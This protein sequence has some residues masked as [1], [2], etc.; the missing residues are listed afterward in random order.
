MTSQL[1]NP[2]ST[3]GGGVNFES[4]V[5]ATFV[6]LM[7][8]GGHAPCLPYWPIVEIKLQ[9]KID[10]FDTD[11]LV[12]IVENV[13][14]KER[15][16][17]LG[18]VKHS[19]GITTGNT[20]FGEV[21]QAAWND[22]NNANIFEKDKDVIALITGPLS[23]VD[24]E[25]VWVL[26]HARTN[27]NDAQRFFRNIQTANFSSKI[28]REKLQVI[29]D[30][31]K[32]ANDGND[33][34]DK[35]FHK[36]LMSFYLLGYDLG[37]EEGVV[38]SLI[39]SHISQFQSDDSR[40]AW[41]R[42][43]EFTCNR[44]QHAGCI[45][46]S[47]L[48]SELT[49][50]FVV[51]PVNEFP[52]ALTLPLV[53][54]TVWTQH[55]DATYLAL[56]VLVGSW[57]DKSQCDL[58]T[59]TQLFGISY[60]EWLRK[61]REILHISDSPLSLKNGVWGVANRVELWKQLSSRILDRDLEAFK[62]LAISVL[63]EPDP[64][65]E[66]A[67]EERYAARVRG[68][69]LSYSA[70]LRIGVAEGL[71][72]LGS[73]LVEDANWSL[74]KNETICALVV[75]AV[76]TDADWVLWGSLNDCLPSL[77]EAA[78]NEFL[79]ATEV[80]L[81]ATPCPF[82]ELFAQ[83]G[84]GVTGGNY[85]VGLLWAL[86]ALAW[87]EQ[88]LVRVCVVLANLS[89]IDPGGRSG[90]RPSSSLATILLPWLPQ[91]LASVEKRKVAIKTILNEQP[92][93]GWKVL[94]RLLPNQYKTSM[95]TYKP[96][97]R[98]II[99]DDWDNEVTR[100][101]YIEQV[102]FYSELA[103]KTAGHDV[104]RLSVLIDQFNNL[105]KTAFD[106]LLDVFASQPIS[107]FPEV[108]KLPL[109]TRLTKFTNKH[110]K[111]SNAKW[112]L[113]NELVVR[114][115]QA[116]TQLAP[117]S[118]FNLYQH[119][120]AGGDFAFYEANSDWDEQQKKLNIRRETAILEI[121]RE[122]G[123][124]GVIRFAESVVLPIQVGI[125]LG[126]IGCDVF[127]P[128]LLPHFLD[129]A[130]KKRA[131]L[132]SGFIRSK[133]HREGWE[134]CDNLEKSNWIPEQV[135]AFLACLPFIKETWERASD[136]LQSH[137]SEYWTRIDI[138]VYSIDSELAA[139]IDKLIEHGRPGVAISCLGR[140]LYA[141]QPVD[142]KQCVQALLAA[143]SNKESN[144]NLSQ[145]EILELIKF[146]QEE[147]SV[148]KDEL[149][150]VEWAYLPLLD[151]YSGGTPKHLEDKL[152]SNPSFFCEVVQ[153]IY[154][155]QKKRHTQNE[156]TKESKAI[157]TNAWELL[158]HWKKIPG[159]LSDGSFDSEQFAEW[160]KQVKNICTESGHLEVALMSVGE[161][162]VYAP[163]DPSGL[164]MHHTVAKELNAQDAEA[165]RDGFRSGKYKSIG[166]Q[167]VD[168]SG[169]PERDLAIQFR[170]QAEEIENA[171]FYRFAIT[172]RE[173]A[174]TYDYQANKVVD[175]YN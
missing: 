103:I 116:T 78:P 77:A 121:F 60:D 38:L 57:Q 49:S 164:W 106:Q 148:D 149:Y 4:H 124:E 52:L 1:S 45:T 41:S 34:S 7:L 66:L 95:G 67:P 156:T 165:M 22:F 26:N 53:G 174:E 168:P 51:K 117:T 97:W 129:S 170:K 6:T 131:A 146:L 157:A 81:Q 65:F 74:G 105:P 36:F 108:K 122:D 99:P 25:V 71:A 119:L 40:L 155:S 109:W 80:A 138:N 114:I 134:W 175:Q 142:S 145:Y 70:E 154:R 115:E 147:P 135:G 37:E 33:L 89:A 72:I 100:Q 144:H 139:G 21:I 150:R 54:S 101:E 167:F 125:A 136:W 9:G 48:P 11:D 31:L 43:L 160:I 10:G 30:H 91:T 85:L 76:L 83:E 98:K 166:V 118:P 35:V 137:E 96:S 20:I 159:T 132:V 64:A 75:R 69:V 113:S 152:A 59:I 123:I 130:N 32:A 19:I 126:A 68:K 163:S 17:L 112:A 27:K 14:S 8:T 86:E 5:Q 128:V 94:V 92:E 13:I 88:Y 44:N 63:Q 140:M 104:P 56:S 102:C 12:V 141:K 120:F 90:N 29:R 58:E 3:G 143:V 73:Q 24:A 127:D 171:G 2:F 62:T 151:G 111:H 28:K 55:P 93:I 42:I 46:P 158:Y 16:K 173:L 161:V 18:Q 61:A 162:L 133:Y 23:K 39:N 82:E 87:G 84:N 107:E 153:L 47:D 15:R 110:R 172:L 79:D 50:I 169:A